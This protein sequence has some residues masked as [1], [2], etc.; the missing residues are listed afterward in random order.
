MSYL[1]EKD[2]AERWNM[3]V[4]SIQK[5]RSSIKKSGPSYVVIGQGTIRYR[6]EDVKA[7]EETCETGGYLPPQAKRALLRHAAM[8]TQLAASPGT[9]DAK[10]KLLEEAAAEARRVANNERQ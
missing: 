10:R 4:S 5:Y 2:L 3:S 1:T 8:F 9:S 7:Y 6:P